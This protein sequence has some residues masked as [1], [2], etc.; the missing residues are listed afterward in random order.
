MELEALATDLQ[1]QL[2]ETVENF[3]L[4]R[5]MTFDRAAFLADQST[6]WR[7]AA[8]EIICSGIEKPLDS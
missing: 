4:A 3:L 1:K 7:Q 6:D 2:F 8:L 5:G